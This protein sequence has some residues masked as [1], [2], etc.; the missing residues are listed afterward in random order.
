[1]AMSVGGEGGDD[2]PMS[3]INTTP[4]VDIMLVLLIIFLIAVPV[5]IKTVKVQ[6]PRVGYK[7]TV[8]KAEN[9]LLSVTGGQGGE[10]CHV[11]QNLTPLTY[12]TLLGIAKKRYADE[13]ARLT[14]A[15]QDDPDNY[16]EVH[17]RGDRKTAY[18]CIGGAVFAIQNAGFLKV[19][20]I[21]T[22]NDN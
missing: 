17:I 13:T 5:A 9:L 11:Y 18:K 4:L 6:L 20:F 19:G 16:P 2:A 3:D 14:P 22:P 10:L 21:S 7:P 8:S 12:E 1:M 15:E